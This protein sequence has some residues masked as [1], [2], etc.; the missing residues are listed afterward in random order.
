MGHEVPQMIGQGLALFGSLAGADAM[1][2]GDVAKQ[3]LRIGWR[4][5]GEHIGRLVLPAEA[6]VEV[7][8]G[9][10]VG[11]QDGDVALKSPLPLAGRGLGVGV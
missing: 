7:P 5:E 10:V 3:P 8:H 1:G 11:K 2:Q 4:W 6:G 9:L